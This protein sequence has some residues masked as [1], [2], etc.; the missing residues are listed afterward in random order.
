MGRPK[1]QSDVFSIGL[2]LYRMF[3]GKLPEWPFEWP[4]AGY[5]K[6]Q[7]RVRPELIRVLRKAIQLDPKKR[8][9]DAVQMYTEFELLHSGARKQKR[10]RAKRGGK[11]GTRRGSS[12]RQQQWREFQRS[13]KAQLDTRHQCRRCEGPVSE[14]MQACPWCGFDKPA[15]GSETRMPAHC[16]RCERGVKNDWDYCPWC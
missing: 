10:P 9:S 5:D 1:F 6:L 13:F 3:S 16:P 7:A 2:V 4:L 12:W 11:N 15:L 8:Y 14:S